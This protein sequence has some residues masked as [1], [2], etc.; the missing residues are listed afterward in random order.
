MSRPR[1]YNIIIYGLILFILTICTSYGYDDGFVS[2]RKI[3]S[4]H[5]SISL[6]AQVEYAQLAQKLNVTQVDRI[7]VDANAKA[8]PLSTLSEMLDILFS[9]VCNTLD[10]QLYSFKGNIKICKDYEQLNTIYKNLFSKDLGGVVSFYVY[11]LNTIYVSAE[12]FKREVLGH[13]IAHAVISHYFVVQP[14]MKA[15]E[16]LAGY[17]E[18]QLR[19]ATK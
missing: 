5:F 18:Y 17:V 4:E 16:V 1:I 8:G 10:M 3:E 12:S 2:V 14:P 19:E 15:Q 6:A 11:D 9:R 7:M 13:E